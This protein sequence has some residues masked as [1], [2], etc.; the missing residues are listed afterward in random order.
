MQDT[1]GVDKRNKKL[2]SAQ[3]DASP[4][5]RFVFTGLNG[6]MER[7]DSNL[8]DLNVTFTKTRQYRKSL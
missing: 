5:T 7:G 2:A 1:G 6:S 3:M 8:Y 4:E